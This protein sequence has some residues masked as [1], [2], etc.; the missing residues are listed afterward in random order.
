MRRAMPDLNRLV[1][2]E[3]RAR[4]RRKR[5]IR[6]FIEIKSKD[7]AHYGGSTELISDDRNGRV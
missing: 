5:A 1:R 7:E 4:S 2:Y 6:S 3:R